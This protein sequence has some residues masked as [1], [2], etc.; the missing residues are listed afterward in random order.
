M[1]RIT[2]IIRTRW[3]RMNT[4][5]MFIESLHVREMCFSIFLRTLFRYYLSKRKV[6]TIKII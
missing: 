6:F 1:R 3:P 2:I 5:S 4:V